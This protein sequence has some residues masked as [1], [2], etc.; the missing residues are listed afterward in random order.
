MAV[1]LYSGLPASKMKKMLEEVL[2]SSLIPAMTGSESFHWWTCF[3]KAA[4]GTADLPWRKKTNNLTP[5]LRIQP[6]QQGV[7]S[8][9]K[10]L[11]LELHS[12]SSHQGGNCHKHKYLFHSILRKVCAH[13]RQHCRLPEDMCLKLCESK[14]NLCVLLCVTVLI[15]LSK[16]GVSQETPSRQILTAY[17]LG[18]QFNLISKASV[19]ISFYNSDHGNVHESSSKLCREHSFSPTD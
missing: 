5:I 17:Q 10:G 7:Q 19:R 4:L 11:L 14:G 9:E 13:S 8:I 15:L 3:S 1:P 18:K 2:T 12:D 6:Q 16:A